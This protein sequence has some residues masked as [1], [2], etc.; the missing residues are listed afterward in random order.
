M[1]WEVQG[2]IASLFSNACKMVIFLR[3]LCV[4][5]YN[6]SLAWKRGGRG[7]PSFLTQYWTNSGGISAS[8]VLR[9]VYY[10]RLIQQSHNKV[11]RVNDL[12]RIYPSRNRHSI[13]LCVAVRP[14]P[15]LKLFLSSWPRT[16]MP[17]GALTKLYINLCRSPLIK[18]SRYKLVRWKHIWAISFSQRET[19]I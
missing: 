14:I 18:R 17:H 2:L 4:C 9:K 15:N 16:D 1:T 10:T 7:R 5:R 12:M 6:L 8:C 3:S 13:W 11:I 19:T